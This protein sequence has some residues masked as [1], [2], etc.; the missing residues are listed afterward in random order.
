M[1]LSTDIAGLSV[2]ARSY[3]LGALL[4]MSHP[5]AY[6]AATGG[7]RFTTG[8]VP[9]PPPPQ[10]YLQQSRQ[11]G[12]HPLRAPAVDD[13]S[14][15]SGSAMRRQLYKTKFCRHYIRGSCKY[16]DHCTYAHC[17][18]ELAARPNFY[19]TKICTRPSCCDPD[20]QY[21]HSIYE[22][23]DFYSRNADK[24]CPAFVVG[25]CNDPSCPMSHSR[26]QAS[27][28][29]L[30][31]CFNL[32]N[33]D[34]AKASRSISDLLPSKVSEGTPVISGPAVATKLAPELSESLLMFYSQRGD[35][36]YQR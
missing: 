11:L 36:R 3:M 25:Q 19:K 14:S 31:Q 13:Q 10:Y 32:V 28:M 30:A 18:E 17:V 24:I 7:R 8:S 26:I 12:H 22:L 15:G 5:N 34:A 9:P 2:S 21:A 20:C 4:P 16:G 33:S 27:E 1:V 6:S 35:Y 29:I 23:R